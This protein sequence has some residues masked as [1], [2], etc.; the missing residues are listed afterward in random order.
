MGE[1]PDNRGGGFKAQVFSQLRKTMRARLCRGIHAA[2]IRRIFALLGAWGRRFRKPGDHNGGDERCLQ[3][4]TASGDRAWFTKMRKRMGARRMAIR[5]KTA[6]LL[7]SVAAI[8]LAGCASDRSSGVWPGS[9]APTASTSSGPTLW[10]GSSSPAPR[11]SGRG[12]FSDT[13]SQAFAATGSGATHIG[14]RTEALRQ[15]LARLQNDIEIHSQEYA[16]IRPRAESNAQAY[17]A[18]VAPIYARLQVG[19]TPGNPEL[20][21][22]WSEA[23]RR[24]NIVNQDIDGLNA[25]GNLVVN[26]AAMASYLLEN[27]R[28]T[29]GL[30][31]AYEEDHRQ[32]ALLEDQTSQTVI[33]VD[34]LLSDISAD[35][36]RQGNYVAAERS[37][38]TALALAIKTGSF[39]ES[40]I[41]TQSLGAGLRGGAPLVVVRFDQP[42]LNFEP[43][44]Q[45]AVRETLAAN[46]N[47]AFDV[48]AVSSDPTQTARARDRAERVYRAMTRAGVNP[49]RVDLSATTGTVAHDEVQIYQ[50]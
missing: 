14:L 38:L 12:F 26:D 31:G 24:L 45:A 8:T 29:Y 21:Q 20:V 9:S 25:L 37:N 46:P 6:A 2:S 40:P 22:Q 30:S 5:F 35:I 47:A 15:D 32:L 18:T 17:Q 7:S 36:D 33:R 39:F 19:T 34:R 42:N 16:N 50:R 27:I 3:H 23:D 4:Q 1:A 44:L 48:V 11:S 13:P 10:G 49:D 43:A 41:R 28:A